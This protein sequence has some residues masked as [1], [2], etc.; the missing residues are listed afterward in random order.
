MAHF[1]NSSF[2]SKWFLFIIVLLSCCVSSKKSKNSETKR[3][4]EA[5]NVALELMN[6][7]QMLQSGMSKR[8]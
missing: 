2:S 4:E 5:G 3:W 8:K 1:S 7:Y 6:D